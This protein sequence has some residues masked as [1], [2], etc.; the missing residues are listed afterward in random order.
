MQQQPEGSVSMDNAWRAAVERAK[1]GTEALI[2]TEAQVLELE[3]QLGQAHAEIGRLRL[4]VEQ[5][6]AQDND[7]PEPPKSDR[8]VLADGSEVACWHTEPNSPC[9][10]NVCRQKGGEDGQDQEQPAAAVGEAVPTHP[11]SD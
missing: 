6:Q 5:L 7:Q 9:D 8:V 10:W 11:F 4:E 3:G 2:V 1:R